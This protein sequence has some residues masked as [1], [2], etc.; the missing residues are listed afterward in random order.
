M[1]FPWDEE[2]PG[3]GG[4][5]QSHSSPQPHSAS[6]KASPTAESV[7]DA[8]EEVSETP[9]TSSPPPAPASPQVEHVTPLENDEERLD[10]YQNDEQLRY[11]TIDG[12]L[13]GEQEAP[14]PAQR[15]LVELHLTLA[16]PFLMQ[17]QKMILHGRQ[18]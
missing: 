12:I 11:R 6:P 2:V 17:R 4:S 16:N 8:G 9:R 5:M 14:P 3:A 10:A 7:L 13:G 18:Q 15:L 1:D